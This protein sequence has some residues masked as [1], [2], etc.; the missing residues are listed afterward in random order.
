M[1]MCP[2]KSGY[3]MGLANIYSDAGS[4]GD[5]NRIRGFMK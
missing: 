1:I 4:Y 2:E 5:G 3:Y